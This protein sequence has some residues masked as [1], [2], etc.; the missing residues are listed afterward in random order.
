MT[1]WGRSALRGVPSWSSSQRFS[2][3]RAESG[4]TPFSQPNLR[5]WTTRFFEAPKPAMDGIGAAGRKGPRRILWRYGSGWRNNSGLG[6][7]CRRLRKARWSSAWTCRWA[8]TPTA[9]M[10]G[11]IATSLPRAWSW[12]RRQMRTFPRASAGNFRPWCRAQSGPGAIS[13]RGGRWLPTVPTRDCCALTTPWA[14][15]GSSG[16][17]PVPVQRRGSTWDGLPTTCT[18]CLRW[19]LPERR[20]SWSLRTWAV[21]PGSWSTR[22]SGRERSGCPLARGPRGTPVRPL[23]AIRVAWQA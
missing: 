10:P 4:S 19:R 13:P 6:S 3:R 15:T 22:W 8:C 1:T 9:T 18:P 11:G 7:N 16:C 5:S 2:G 17:P 14:C 21:N 20:R 23:R 12:G